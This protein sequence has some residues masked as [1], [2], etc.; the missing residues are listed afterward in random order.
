[1]QYVQSTRPIF[2]ETTDL[3][4]ATP[5]YVFRVELEIINGISTNGPTTACAIDLA[6]RKLIDLKFLNDETLIIAC[7]EPGASAST[8][9]QHLSSLF[10]PN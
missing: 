9:S 4:A 1:M 8:K 7:S 2:G 10:A 6:D 3:H 5:V